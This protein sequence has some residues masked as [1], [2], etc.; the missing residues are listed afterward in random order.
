MRLPRDEY[1]FNGGTSRVDTLSGGWRWRA[2]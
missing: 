2:A 1:G